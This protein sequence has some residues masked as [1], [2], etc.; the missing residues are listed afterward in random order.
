MLILSE[1]LAE[2]I[3]DRN[4]FNDEEYK[5]I[6]DYYTKLL[7]DGIIA[8]RKY[9]KSID[10]NRYSVAIREIQLASALEQIET[11]EHIE[12][13]KAKRRCRNCTYRY[14]S[15]EKSQITPAANCDNYEKRFTTIVNNFNN[16]ISHG[17]ISDVKHPICPLNMYFEG[18]EDKFNIDKCDF[19]DR[20]CNETCKKIIENQKQFCPLNKYT[21]EDVKQGLIDV[22][23]CDFAHQ[24]RVH[25]DENVKCCTQACFLKLKNKI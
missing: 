25:P 24:P 19:E 8:Y 1:F 12:S 11:K 7:A 9:L 4:D 21:K 3:L 22:K 10:T 14:T 13:D 2:H 16:E 15:C 6:L 5:D 18:D 17:G 20:A 23:R